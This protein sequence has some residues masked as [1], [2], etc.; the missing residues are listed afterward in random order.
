MSRTEKN[1]CL[2][3]LKAV[4]SPMREADRQF[5]ERGIGSNGNGNR[6]LAYL[7]QMLKKRLLGQ[8]K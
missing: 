2:E 6:S 8:G 1:L 3:Y 4:K 5:I 7:G